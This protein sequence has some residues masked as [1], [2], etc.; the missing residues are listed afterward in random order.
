[1]STF[2]IT[3]N[4]NST[5]NITGSHNT[6]ILK[7]GHQVVTSFGDGIFEASSLSDNNYIVKGSV[8]AS[9]FMV[10]AMVLGGDDADVTIAKGGVIEGRKGI[11][12]YGDNATI[13]NSGKIDVDETGVEI[14]G[15]HSSMVN[16]GSITSVAT[17]A[18][19]V[20]NVDS[21]SFVNDGKITGARGIYSEAAD[22]VVKLGKHSV[23]ETSGVTIE[24]VTAYNETAKIINKGE[25]SADGNIFSLVIEGHDGNETVRNSG[26]ING[27]ISLGGSSDTYNGRGGHVIGVINGGD[28]SDTYI[29]D[30]KKDYVFEAADQGH[31]KLTVS[32]SMTL[33]NDNHIETIYLSGKRNVDLHGNDD[34]NSLI[35]NS[36]NNSLS[37]DA[38]NDWLRGGRGTDFLTGG[39]G[40]D[41]FEFATRN[42]KEIV[43]DFLDGV[44]T[45][46]LDMGANHDITSVQDLLAH[47][48]HQNGADLVISGDGTTM[49]IRNFDRSDLTI[50]DF[51]LD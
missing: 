22:L 35:G 51:T 34:G 42:G 25:M 11:M 10:S 17:A 33:G 18:L 38:G 24:T 28:G 7:Q 36:G 5:Y 2:T 12:S 3:Q 16:H 15:A 37:G 27:S 46:Q 44:D 4:Q 41:M 30:N 6:W 29:L 21:F 14:H 20:L 45:L 39:E 47:H 8:S 31:D 26:T 40:V 48:T 23:I 50:A 19:S 32:F 1:M 13:S 49:I 43:T 9:G